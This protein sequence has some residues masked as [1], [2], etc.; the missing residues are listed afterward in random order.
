M[1]VKFK[2]EFCKG[3]MVVFNT[4]DDCA[5]HIVVNHDVKREDLRTVSIAIRKRE[6]R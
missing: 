5:D 1:G 3:P 6:S 4:I 2:C